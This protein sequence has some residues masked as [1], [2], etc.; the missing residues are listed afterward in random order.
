LEFLR[1]N[2][3][4]RLVLA[5]TSPYRKELLQRLGIPFEIAAPRVDETPL[6]GESPADMALRL[7]VLKAK[8]VQGDVVIGCD[9]AAALEG[10]LVGKPGDH[11]TAVKQLRAMSGKTVE[12]HTALTVKAAAVQSRVVP[13]RVTFR[14]L[15]DRV[16]E[17]YLQKEKP[18]D[19]AGSAKAE[20]LGIA[21]IARMETEDPTSLIGLPLIALT[22]MLERAGVRV[23]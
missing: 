23:L 15:S 9:Q 4:M 20:G 14:A 10:R 22:G 16:I 8:A 13:C 17:A 18:Y 6:S 1:Q 3:V 2:N 7:S 12:F 19:C 11:A 5:S 21:L